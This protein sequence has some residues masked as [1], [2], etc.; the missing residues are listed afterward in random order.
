MFYREIGTRGVASPALMKVG[1]YKSLNPDESLQIDFLPLSGNRHSRG[2]EFLT[3]RIPDS[4]FAMVLCAPFSP[5][6]L[7]P[8]ACD[9]PVHKTTG[10]S[11][12]RSFEI[13]LA[14]IS[15][16]VKVPKSR[17]P[18]HVRVSSSTSPLLIGLSDIARS[19]F[20]L[21]RFPCTRNARNAEP[22]LLGI[23]RHVSLRSTVLTVSGNRRS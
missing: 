17:S 12:Y 15:T 16:T 10:P 14:V 3:S 7:T 13:P 9:L 6:R 21:Q 19:R 18:I 11:L 4:R 20:L 1:Y 22:R 8:R 2:R 5:L 23:S